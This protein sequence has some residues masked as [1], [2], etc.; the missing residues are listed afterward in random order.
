MCL[1]GWGA[2]GAHKA[3]WA[4]TRDTRDGGKTVAVQG[5]RDGA[6]ITGPGGGDTMGA[7]EL[8]GTGRFVGHRPNVPSAV[9][10]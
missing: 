2:V 6:A 9:L 4:A 7:R 10:V 1:L 3:A 5:W 8:S